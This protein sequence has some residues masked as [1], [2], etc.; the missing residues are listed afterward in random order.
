MLTADGSLFDSCLSTIL[1]LSIKDKSME[2]DILTSSLWTAGVVQSNVP[3]ESQWT[4][5]VYCLGVSDSYARDTDRHT[6]AI[7]VLHHLVIA[8]GSLTISISA[9][10]T[11]RALCSLVRP[12]YWVLN[13]CCVT[14][15]NLEECRLGFSKELGVAN[16]VT[17][18][19]SCK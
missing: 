18:S 13:F 15:V 1:Q 10:Y 11:R 7:A 19:G 3:C 16:S 9:S 2:L 17:N 5:R 4:I 12:E 8:Q 6:V 14:V